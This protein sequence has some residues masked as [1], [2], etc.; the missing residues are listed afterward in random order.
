LESIINYF[1]YT[2]IKGF[3][4]DWGYIAILVGTFFE[5]ETIV[6]LAGALSALGFMSLP[7]VFITGLFGTFFGDQIYFSIGKRW[8]TRLLLRRPSMKRKSRSVFRLLK[9]YETAFILSFRFIY[10]LRNVSPFVIGMNGIPHPR[11]AALNLI[12]ATAWAIAFAG[13]G[14]MIGHT[15]KGMLDPEM[16]DKIHIYI[17][18]TIVGFVGTIALISILI[19][20]I[21]GN[22]DPRI[23]RLRRIQSIRAAERAN[24]ESDGKTS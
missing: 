7:L 1:G 10:G 18:V 24:E 3:L 12:A 16:M 20:R 2:D 23:Q 19:N 14:Y 6:I 4:Q 17:F 11:F 21:R 13:G 5:G 15:F 9:K 8:G 22:R